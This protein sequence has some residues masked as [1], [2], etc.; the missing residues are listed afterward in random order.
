MSATALPLP[1][2]PPLDPAAMRMVD[3]LG[4]P[5]CL[6]DGA[7]E[8]VHCNRHWLE[9]GPADFS[10]YASAVV[11]G[12]VQRSSA[13]PVSMEFSFAR[14]DG[15]TAW[16]LL[17]LHP[18]DGDGRAPRHW[19]CITVDIQAMKEREG[20]LREREAIRTEMLNISVDCIK[21]IDTEGRLVHLNSAGC[22]AL[23]VS[24][25]QAPGKVWLSLLP[26]DVHAE[27]EAALA[28]ALAGKPAR[29][30]GRSQLPGEPE[31]LWDNM[32]TPVLDGQGRTTA[33]LCVSRE[34]TAE[35]KALQSL[36][37]SQER[38]AIAA[39]VG[40]LGI[41]DYDIAND[42]LHCDASW[43]RIMGLDSDAHPV[44]SIADF[45][46]LIHPE[47][48]E[49]A[50]E[51]SRTAAELIEQERDYA[52]VF[53]II[54]PNGDV[55]WVRSLT[56]L[57]QENGVATRAVGFLA[58][59]TDAW[60]G[61]LALRD[62]NRALEQEKSSLARQL[63]EDPLTG[64]ANRRHLDS[65]L[66]RICLRAR[67]L[68]QPVCVGMIDV[69]YF[70]RFN[71]RY[72]HVQGDKALREIAAALQAVARNSDFVARYGGEEFAFV[73]AG[74]DAPEQVVERFMGKIASLAIPNEDAPTG[75][76][77]ISCGVVVSSHNRLSP[78]QLLR[79][80]DVALYAAKRGGRNRYVVRRDCEP[81]L[82]RE[83][84][85]GS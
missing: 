69:D 1:S 49:R 35:R 74:T 79:A 83:A 38:L 18:L 55:R 15:R 85:S 54:R 27:G 37:E 80:G 42:C 72:G 78:Q 82:V 39:R 34:V 30:P 51:I 50:T 63:L 2:P 16:Y 44:R 64:I 71:D 56:Y 62:A 46:P 67:E 70:K 76:L 66:A 41:W 17:Q 73:L 58:D 40:G 84:L 48:A 29:F 8:L 75:R 33:V 68:G 3:L 57:H 20:E 60:R 7:G 13:G 24:E 21:L 53:R 9:S 47:D 36:L 26:P 59:I 31:Q 81:S 52:I 19:L 11:H 65:E 6:L 43:Y 5:A 10:G 22:K 23:G 28:Q 14:K 25:D 4:S 61:E 45:R 77:T 12:L 32:L